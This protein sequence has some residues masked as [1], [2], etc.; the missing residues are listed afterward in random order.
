MIKLL[1]RI[2]KQLVNRFILEELNIVLN[3]MEMEHICSLN[4]PEFI[5]ELDN[6]KRE[7]MEVKD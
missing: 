1:K 3:P 2:E 5:K 6:I 7:E 4:T